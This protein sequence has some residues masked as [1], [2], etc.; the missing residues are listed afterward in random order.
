M[1]GN[2][3]DADK[4][5]AAKDNLREASEGMHRIIDNDSQRN[6]MVNEI[7]VMDRAQESS[8]QG[9][10]ASL[11]RKFGDYASVPKKKV[12]DFY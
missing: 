5:S 11:K 2:E 7:A 10:G 12:G 6:G 4:V 3:E 9:A 8:Y 1:S